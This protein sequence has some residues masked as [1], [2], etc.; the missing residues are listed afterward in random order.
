MTGSSRGS[1][2]ISTRHM[3][4]LAAAFGAPFD[5]RLWV[6]RREFPGPHAG[7]RS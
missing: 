4:L 2:A 3:L 7:R 5:P 1:L 6:P